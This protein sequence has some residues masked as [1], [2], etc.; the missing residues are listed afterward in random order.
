LEQWGV[1]RS[2]GVVVAKGDCDVDDRSAGVAGG[3]EDGLDR[4]EQMLL[5][6][7]WGHRQNLVLIV[8][9]QKSAALRVK[10]ESHLFLS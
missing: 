6:I 4:L 3:V 8:H 10:R 7:L 5:A 1:S 9:R 2:I